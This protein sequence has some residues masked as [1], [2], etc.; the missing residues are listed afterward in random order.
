MV[1]VYI[2]VLESPYE[3]DTTFVVIEDVLEM[4]SF[5]PII[6]PLVST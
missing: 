4:I 1:R 6:V 5:F 2:P 3:I